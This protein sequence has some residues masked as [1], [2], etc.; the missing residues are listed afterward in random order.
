MRNFSLL[1]VCVSVLAGCSPERMEDLG[2]AKKAPNEHAVSTR[3]PLTL[4]PDYNLRPV[5]ANM[6]QSSSV[7]SGESSEMTSGEKR[8]LEKANAQ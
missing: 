8:L 2:L 1:L 5:N 4:P 7:A 6:A 3:Q